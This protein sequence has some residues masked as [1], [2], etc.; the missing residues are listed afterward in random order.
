[1]ARKAQSDWDDEES[2]YD[3]REFLEEFEDERAS[4]RGRIAAVLGTSYGLSAVV[5]LAGL[6]ALTLIVLTV[7]SEQKPVKLLSSFEQV[8]PP[9]EEKV[10]RDLVKN[11]EVP[12]P[13]PVVD[14]VVVIDEVPE[15][16]PVLKGTDEANASDKNLESTSFNDTYGP[17]GGPPA[18]ARGRRDGKEGL[19]RRGGGE[20][21]ESAVRGALRWLMRAQSADGR[22]DVDNWTGLRQ[23]RSQ[24]P[25]ASEEGHSRYD[26]GVTALALLA[27]YGNGQTH[28]AGPFKRCV[29]RGLRWLL[30]QQR[31]D[32]SIGYTPGVEGTLYNHAIATMLLCDALATSTDARRLREPARR[33]LRLV[34]AAQNPGFGWKYEPRSGH[35]D[36]SVTG[37]MLLA[38]K[39]GRAAGLEV[40][41]EAFTQGLAWID[42]ATDGQ[43]NTGYEGPGGGCAM[44]P[45][46]EGRYDAVPTMTAVGVVSRIFAGQKTSADLVR[47]GSRHLLAEL[48]Q[49]PEP[50][51]TQKVNFYYW[52]YATY[53]L[54]Q[55][56]GKPWQDWNAAMKQ[57]LVPRQRVGGIEDGSWDPVGE[58]CVAGGR[59]YATAINALTLEIYYRYDRMHE[60]LADASPLYGRTEKKVRRR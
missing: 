48:P 21:T 51:S 27:F 49:W 38:L 25:G 60:G 6:A 50:Q 24:V 9:Y 13:E 44:L 1:M 53:A 22:W 36:T 20:E 8:E 34:V 47:K 32:G 14:P 56:D 58:W 4:A 16:T 57:A 29:S 28:R 42:A 3:E 31:S 45:V 59:V 15:P 52:Y 2:Y 17:A 19:R 30:A 11:E 7:P 26:V 55:L 40:P 5:H 18:G 41:E 37:W 23:H 35:N 46:N 43:G 39:S 33:A 12:L 54:F 10:K